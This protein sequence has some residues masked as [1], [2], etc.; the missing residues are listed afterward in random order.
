M[1]PPKASDDE[2]GPGGGEDARTMRPATNDP[3]ARAKA[4]AMAQRRTAQAKRQQ[5]EQSAEGERPAAEAERRGPVL[6]ARNVVNAAVDEARPEGKGDRPNPEQRR[7]Q[8][9]PGAAPNKKAAAAPSK[10][11]RLRELEFVDLYVPL[12]ANGVARYNPKDVRV[13]EPGNVDVTREYEAD[14]ARLREQLHLIKKE[15]FSLAHD[16]VRYRGSRA[17]LANGEHWVCLRRISGQVPTLEELKVDELLLPVLR[18]LGRRNG[19]IIVCGGTGQGKST[20]ANAILADY[21]DRLGHVAM[22]IEDP[23][24]FNMS[25][26]RGNGGYCF[27]V[28]V[29]DDEA[30]APS[31]KRALRWHPRYMLVGEIRSGAAAAQ[32][33]RAATSGH[34]VI[35][36]LH[37]GSVEK[38]IQAMIQ[39][40]ETEIGSRAQELVAEGISAVLHQTLTPTGPEISYIF[41]NPS[42]A[43][44]ARQYIRAGKLHMLNSFMEQQAIHLANEAAG[45]NADG[46]ARQRG[47]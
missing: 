2:Q 44:P 37:A 4:Q 18:G 10:A 24:E 41:P 33:L 3:E 46:T 8:R 14:L 32:V 23:V 11:S 43:D 45:K 28:E 34:L 47:G 6:S 27:Q 9:P 12:H 39:V 17:R 19:L 5:R 38:G 13:G 30:W 31:L 1:G 22:T 40:A 42:G 35:T 36:T 15:D 7:R 25:G 29:E 21:L 20:T 16:E 26:E